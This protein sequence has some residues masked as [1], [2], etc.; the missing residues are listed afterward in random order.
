MSNKFDSKCHIG[1]THGI[2]T[3]VDV[4]DEKDKYS[5]YIYKGVCNEC[6]HERFAHYGG[7]SGKSHIAIKCNHIGADGNYIKPTYW[8]NKRIG[9]IFHGMKSRYYNQNDES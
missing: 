3:L 9:S 5:H 8:N 6:G 1:E 7:F 4:L 2:Y